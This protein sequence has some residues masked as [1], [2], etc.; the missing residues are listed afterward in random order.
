MR[1]LPLLGVLLATAVPAEAQNYRQLSQWC[2]GHAGDA[3]TIA[4]CTAVIQWMR[5]S[6][7]DAAAAFYNRAIA[8]RNQGQLDRALDDYDEAL[9]LRPAFAEAWNDRGIAHR[10]KGNSQRAIA[11]FSE[12]GRLSPD[13]AAAWFNRGSTWFGLG[14][15]DRAIAD[16]DRTLALEP[17]DA[18]ALLARGQAR[19]AAGDIAGG[20]A[21]I[22]AARQSRK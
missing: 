10:S 14:Q 2:F 1:G 3:E 8:Y 12:A 11:D 20:D 15:F 19:R 9:K 4:G 22:A 7:R 13:F 5:E 21:D 17:G 16:F 6:K 18:E